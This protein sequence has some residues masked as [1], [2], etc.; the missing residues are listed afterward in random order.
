MLENESSNFVSLDFFVVC[1]NDKNIFST[2]ISSQ[3][4][5]DNGQFNNLQHWVINHKNEY[6][7][8]FFKTVFIVV[9]SDL[10]KNV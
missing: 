10:F 6:G 2:A 9:E 5:L 8:W 7:N 4:I 1:W 3:Y